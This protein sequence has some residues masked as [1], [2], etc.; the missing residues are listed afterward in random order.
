MF[1]KKDVGDGHVRVKVEAKLYSAFT[2]KCDRLGKTYGKT[3]LLFLEE[4][5]REFLEDK[6]HD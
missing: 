2:E 5:I 1:K 4:K 6:K 3:C